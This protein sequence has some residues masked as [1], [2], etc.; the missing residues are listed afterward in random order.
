MDKCNLMV[1]EI[2]VLGNTIKGNKIMPSREKIA[3]ITDFPIPKNKKQLQQFLG[4][5]KYIGSQ[6]PYIAT[7]Q[8]PLTELTGTQQW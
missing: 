8:A 2:E 1:D 6:L 7:L 3:H 4:S 5:V